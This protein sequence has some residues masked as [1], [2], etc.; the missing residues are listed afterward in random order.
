MTQKNHCPGWGAQFI[1]QNAVLKTHQMK[2]SS[3]VRRIHLVNR[4]KFG[5][6]TVNINRTLQ[7]RISIIFKLV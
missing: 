1:F 6:M 4:Q 5:F 7:Q 3:R 2:N